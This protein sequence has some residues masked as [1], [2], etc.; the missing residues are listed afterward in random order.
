[1]ADG[2]DDT[3]DGIAMSDTIQSEGVLKTRGLLSM[4]E[5]YYSPKIFDYSSIK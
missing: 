5:M 4:I 2:K 3:S 1:V